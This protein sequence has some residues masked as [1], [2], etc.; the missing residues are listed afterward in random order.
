MPTG[1]SA[2]CL[3]LLVPCPELLIN[4]HVNLRTPWSSLL[5]AFFFHIYCLWRP[6]CCF[7][8]TC[9][10]VIRYL[11]N[12]QPCITSRKGQFI[13][14]WRVFRKNH[15]IT[16]PDKV[17]RY[18]S[19]AQTTFFLCYVFTCLKLHPKNI[20]LVQFSLCKISLHHSTLDSHILYLQHDTQ[21]PQP[22]DL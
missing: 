19:P 12:S 2:F 13:W 3:L 7:W 10:M 21:L 8:N 6:I 1:L 11:S 16:C 4:F 17:V 15:F 9:Q 18:H 14:Q 22:D 20:F 5:Q